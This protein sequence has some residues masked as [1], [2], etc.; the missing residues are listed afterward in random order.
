MYEQ[1]CEVTNYGDFSNELPPKES[2]HVKGRLKSHINF[3]ISIGAPSFILSVISEYLTNNQSA[4]AH[5][6]FVHTAIDE[7]LQSGCILEV[8]KS[9]SVVNPLSVSVQRSGKKRLILDLRHVNQSA[10]NKR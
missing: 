2:V 3:W 1:L 6:T 4:L 10:K 8:S 9:P 7:L 5:S